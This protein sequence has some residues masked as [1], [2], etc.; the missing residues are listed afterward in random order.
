MDHSTEAH[1]Q[2]I[3]FDRQRGIR[4]RWFSSRNGVT[5]GDRHRSGD[6]DRQL[7]GACAVR[8]PRE[9]GTGKAWRYRGECGML[10]MDTKTTLGQRPKAWNLNGARAR[11][12]T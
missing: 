12:G 10:E 8:L 11:I 1:S 4:F 2:V 5:D 9:L 3:R 6:S 7:A